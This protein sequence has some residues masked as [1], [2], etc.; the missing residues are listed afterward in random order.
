[1]EYLNNDVCSNNYMDEN[2]YRSS[3]PTYTDDFNKFDTKLLKDV[4]TGINRGYEEERNTQKSKMD[5]LEMIKKSVEDELNDEI[6]Y[7]QIMSQAISQEQKDVLSE[8]IADEKKHNKLL[9][10]VYFKLTNTYLPETNKI[11]KQDTLTYEENLIKALKGECMAA[12]KYRMIMNS[13]DDK[14]CYNILM[15]IMVDELRHIG[16]YNYLLYDLL[17]NKISAQKV[18]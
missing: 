18:N 1:M 10:Q 2:Y 8:I 5:A 15:E 13:I 17:N 11:E 3:T 4:I 16:K 6:F 7:N 12:N 9:R 14:S